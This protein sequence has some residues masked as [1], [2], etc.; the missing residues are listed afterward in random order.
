MIPAG[1]TA[2]EDGTILGPS[3]KALKGTPSGGGHLTFKART[4]GKPR[5]YYVHTVVCETFH[6]PRPFPGAQVRHLDGNKMNNR[7]DNLKWGTA[8]E[9]GEDRVRHGVSARGEQ[10]SQAKL[11][12]AKVRKIRELYST[13]TVST[14]AMADR[15]QVTRG[16]VLAV[17]RGRSWI[18]PH[19][20]PPKGKST[21]RGEQARKAKLTAEQVREIRR[22]YALNGERYSDLA[23][24]YG[25]GVSAIGRIVQRKTWTHI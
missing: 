4:N 16:V 13:G 8:K 6:G 14:Q 5:T 24:E 17:A 3:G 23:A 12:W 18:D 9:N 11:T 21:W 19:Y 1:Y 7:A 2:L 15:F 25:V 20:I 10:S 22:R